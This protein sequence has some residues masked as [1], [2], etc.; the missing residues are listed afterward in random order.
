MNN[1]IIHAR[2]QPK[3]QSETEAD[4]IKQIETLVKR[5]SK[6]QKKRPNYEC[7]A[8]YPCESQFNYKTK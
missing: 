5:F 6:K 8:R 2:M 1:R 3:K 7:C 4:F